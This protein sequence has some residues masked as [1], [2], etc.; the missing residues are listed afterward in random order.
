[1]AVDFVVADYMSGLQR[2][3]DRQG[4]NVRVDGFVG[5]R[6]FEKLRNCAVAEFTI[7]SLRTSSTGALRELSGQLTANLIVMQHLLDDQAEAETFQ[8]ALDVA[9]SLVDETED[10]LEPALRGGSIQVTSIDPIQL[11]DVMRL[12]VSSYMITYTHEIR[13]KRVNEI[14]DPAP[15]VVLLYSRDPKIGAPHSSEYTHFSPEDL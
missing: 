11:D 3:L 9:T 4:V 14:A 7:E 1:M 12:R 10:A 15:P 13:I 8:L 2:L 6:D 5:K